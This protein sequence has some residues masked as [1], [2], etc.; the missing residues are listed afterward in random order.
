MS[1][2]SSKRSGRTDLAALLFLHGAALGVWL[3]PLT[4]ILEAN[5][6]GSI[7]PFAYACGAVGAF[8][9]PLIFGAV[10]D[11]HASPV[12]VLRWLALATACSMGLATLSIHLHWPPFLVLGLI[13]IH[14]LCSA[15]TW[16]I[17][18]TITFSRLTN[19]KQEFG[20]LRAMATFGWMAGCW[21]V[22]GLG[23]DV[24][25]RT[26]FLGGLFW[27]T[28]SGFTWLLPAVD[29]PKS[30]GGLG[31]RERFGLDALALMKN[32][33]H[34]V[35]FITVA[36][37]NIPLAAFYPITPSHL[38]DLGLVHTS[39]W[40]T[41][42]QITEIIAMVCLGR[43][44]TNWRLKWIFSAGLAF[45]VIRF[46]LC[47]LN[48]ELAVLAGITLHGFSYALVFI[49][50]QVY[51]DERVDSAWRGRAQALMA[52]MT[53]GVGNMLGYLGTG[54]WHHASTTAGV[55]RWPLFW[56]WLAVAVGF[57]AAYFLIAY[58]GKGQRSGGTKH[59]VDSSEPAH[60]SAATPEAG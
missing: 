49:T 42:G 12:R 29:P 27:L 55:T 11:R 41:L 57:V 25:T 52:L 6:Y 24:S 60:T 2:I 59:P 20:P 28:I 32:P 14:A 38:R 1:D 21:L 56:T 22:S 26:G 8:V 13:Q 44:M 37:L 50:A 23:T 39:A 40:M 34:R 17:T 31:W 58:H 15:P 16:S 35:V 33:D 43:L 10:A 7:R 47:A 9:T 36:L 30:T 51:L 5:G 19:P 48:T 18:T 54:W 4:G 3:V 46:G 53:S 45:G